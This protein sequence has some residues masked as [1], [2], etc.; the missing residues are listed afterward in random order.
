MKSKYSFRDLCGPRPR[1]LF[2]LGMVALL[3][4]CT[5]RPAPL[6]LASPRQAE[7]PPPSP[8]SSP[9]QT[10]NSPPPA[11]AAPRET[12]F[13][14]L[15]DGQT[16]N[17]WT[18]VGR[19]GDGFG[20]TNGVIYCARGGGGNLFTEQEFE[21]FILRFEFKLEDGANSG[22]G[23]RSPL[24]GDPA[25]LGME[26]QILDEVGAER[27]QAGRLQ[28]EQFH[29]SIY[30]VLPARKGALRPPGEWNTEEITAR[31]RHLKVVVN[32]ITILEANLNTVSDPFTIAKHPGLF[33]ES[34]H[35]GL[36]GQN[37]Y[38][39]FR[40]I[41]LKALPRPK[42]AHTR[43]EG[44]TP[45]FNGEDLTGWKGLVADP[46]QRATMKPAE[47]AAKQAQANELMHANWRVEDGALVYRG[48][49]FDNL[50]TAKDYANFELVAD[51]KIAPHSDSGFYLRGTPQVQIW[52]PFTAP[53]KAG[54]AVGS[55][56]LFN[57]QT[58]AARPLRV[59][60]KPVGEW[61][62]MRIILVG[63]R[64][65]VFLNDELV[66]NN[67]VL[68]NYW[69]RDLALFP[70]GPIE[71]QAHQTPVWFKNLHVRELPAR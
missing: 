36:L 64:V 15:F 34:G 58:N 70:I 62:R 6:I 14:S 37:D 46:K 32:D 10:D 9:R 43:P 51:W 45:L 20:V 27:G 53:A 1:V 40:Q 68:E 17:G 44:F 23:I 29:G 50:C 5:S 21:D 52:D 71:L 38:V 3:A 12:G 42:N 18:L 48:T 69:Q 8:A 11:D 19:R 65:H 24:E 39:E 31:G 30:D 25:S 55:G 66:V 49:N 61:N 33:R 41:R 22:I 35:I 47:L 67:T 4:S 2:A 16:L 28:P 54:T 13:T 7:V 63:D 57:N 56:G 26:V 60:D 59:A